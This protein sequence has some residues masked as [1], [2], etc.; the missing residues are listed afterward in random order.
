LGAPKCGTTAL[1]AWLSSHRQVFMAAAKEPHHFN[2]DMRHRNFAR[3]D[4]Y[5]RLF[6]R[7]DGFAAVGEASVWYLFSDAAVPNIENYTSGAR[8]VVCLRD[9]VQMAYSLHEQQVFSGNENETD[10]ARAWKLGPERR[11]GRCVPDSAVDPS[12]LVYPEACAI[13]SQLERL[14]ERVPRERVHLVGMPG[15]QRDPRGTFEGVQRF[16]G[17][18]PDAA[19]ELPVVNAAKAR[20]SLAL[21]R[22][23][24]H[25]GRLKAA[26]GVNARFGILDRLDDANRTERPRP[27][28]DPEFRAMLEQYFEPEVAI[29]RR[30]TGIDLASNR[31]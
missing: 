29:V 11:E 26:L 7:A 16:L 4:E 23:T 31:T 25:L 22:L 10:F 3:R 1:A 21:Q 28:M 17:L 30:L 12:T 13:G 8:Y 27:A 15:L 18:I 20:K 19:I 9:P 5:E 24:R 6:E 2:T 14:L